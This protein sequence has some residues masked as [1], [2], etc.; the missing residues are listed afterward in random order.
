M[1]TTQEAPEGERLA[2]VEATLDSLTREVTSVWA[3]ISDIRTEMRD[4]RAEI[5]DLRSMMN[6]ILL[7]MVAMWI[8]TII[9]ILFRTQ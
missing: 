7:I 3:A 4:I 5:R 6:R 9:T 2:R 1:T 8:T